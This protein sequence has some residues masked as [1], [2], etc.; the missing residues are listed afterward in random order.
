M[1]GVTNAG[2]GSGLQLE[3]LISVYVNAEKAPKEAI[4]NQKEETTNSQLSGIGQ[5]KS[6]LSTFQ[7]VVKKLTDP[8]A[9]DQNTVAITGP[10]T[11]AFSVETN[12]ASKGNFQVE[13][14]Q[15][16]K[17]TRLSSAAIAGGSSTTFGAGKLTFN[18][19]DKSL[20]ITVDD[21]DTLSVIR[22][23]INDAGGDLGVSANII[24]GDDGAR[25]TLTSNTTGSAN[26]LTVTS[27][28]D[29]SLSALSTGLSVTQAA[30]DAVITV[31]GTTISSDTNTFKDAIA[32]VTLTAKA[33]TT[34][35]NTL[36]VSRD[37]DGI[38]SMIKDFVDGYNALKASLDTLGAP[39][40]GGDGDD[41]VAGGALAFDPLVRSIKNQTQNALTGSIEALSGGMDSLYKVG[42]TFDNS[43]KMEILSYGI[44]NGPSG[45][46]RLT[47]AINNNAAQLGE[48]FARNNPTGNDSKDKGFA[49]KLDEILT[50]YTEPKGAIAERQ[51][52]L[53][54]TL[55]SISQQRDDLTLRL[56]NYEATMRAQFDALDQIVAQYQSTGD[57][58]TS[59]LA[60][61]P[62][63]KSKD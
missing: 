41:S 25:L 8:K 22:Q 18:V 16:A 40:S 52:S 15:L 23:K 12:N 7:D 1:A 19:G 9:F 55:K 24:N 45:E 35:A 37:T 30:Q 36:D 53:N 51:G 47:D 58:L 49:V 46:D 17:G 28:G 62:S 5:L 10:N 56:S 29:A 50:S 39:G 26:N 6:A 44:G 59:A 33:V 48:L 60:S 43:G 11:D 27:T 63:V 2:I 57:Y 31:D 3:D 4:L 20:D 38:K 21:G 42:I 13:V 32:G 14:Q 54:D 34:G 61:L